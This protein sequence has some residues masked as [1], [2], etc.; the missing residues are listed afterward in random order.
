MLTD[1]KISTLESRFKNFRIC[2]RIRRMRA[3]DSRIRK[4]KVADSKITGYVWLG[5]KS[6]ALFL[7]GFPLFERINRVCIFDGFLGNLAKRFLAYQCA[8]G[9]E[10]FLIFQIFPRLRA[11]NLQRSANIQFAN[12]KIDLL[13]NQSKYR[14]SL[15]HLCTLSPTD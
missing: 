4:E 5:P 1:S 15:T 12:F 13:G 2:L 14:K 9:C 11:L 6:R 3:A 7:R 8:K 10:D